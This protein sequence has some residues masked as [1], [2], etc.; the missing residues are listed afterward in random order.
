MSIF[1]LLSL[2]F[3]GFM[4][5]VVRLKSTRYRASRVELVAWY[6]IWG[7]FA[8]L[9]LFPDILRGAVGA[10]KFA[11]VF[12]LLIVM[13][14]MV[15]SLLV[16]F[17]YFA[18]KELAEKLETYVRKDAITQK[19]FS[20]VLM[21][22]LKQS[23]TF[24][25]VTPSYNQ[26]QF[27]QKTIDSVLS[28]QGDFSIQYHIADGGSTDGTKEILE[29]LPEHV[30]WVSEKDSGQTDAI[31]KGIRTLL[32]KVKLDPERTILAYINSDDMYLPHAFE[33]VMHTFE[34]NPDAAWVVGDARIVDVS[35]R[36]IQVGV[37]WYKIILRKVLSLFLLSIVNPIPQPSVFIRLSAF[38]KT[39]FFDES[40]RYT[41]D[42]D[43][44]HRL[45]RTCGKPT[46]IP[47]ELSA[48]R[49]HGASKGGAQYERQFAEQY[50]VAKRYTSY[51]LARSLHRLHNF[52]IILLYK[53]LK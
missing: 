10:L 1:Q 41:M 45:Y 15:L 36:R 40:L 13:A 35:D 27:I 48:F 19:N 22:K 17:L 47:H 33:R 38:Q 8:F 7:I 2:L 16:V 21:K 4:I 49:I 14:F 39:G 44:W 51:P 3:A 6:S 18:V 37:R 25:I 11:R 12:D 23:Y 24:L 29:K 20:Q 42:Y 46:V 50:E 32:K 28:Q 26:A 5:Y 53:K 43:Y 9:S 52:A 30:S 31:N 34:R